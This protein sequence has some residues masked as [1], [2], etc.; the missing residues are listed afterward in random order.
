MSKRLGIFYTTNSS[1]PSISDLQ[2]VQDNSNPNRI[3]VGNPD[4]KPNYVH[5]LRIN[6][7][8]WQAMTGKYIWSGANATL[9]NNAFANST[10]FD[11]FGR[12]T[13]KTENVDGNFFANIFAG[14]GFPILNRKIEFSPNVNAS[15]TKYSNFINSQQ[16]ITKNTALSGGL[17]IEFQLDS[18]EIEIS[19]S[20]SYNNPVSSLSASSNLP[21]SAQNYAIDFKWTLPAHIIVEFDAEYSINSQRANGYNKNLF[22]INAEIKKEFGARQNTILSIQAN[23]ILNQNLTVQR[24]LNG[25]IVTDNFTK[26]ISRYFLMKLTYKFNNNKTKEDDFSGWH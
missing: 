18:L 11:S 19:Q 14:V 3:K 7:N 22:I 24:Q 5:N 4:L 10:N 21:Y 17:S 16:N 23:D 13:S 15:Y 26:I 6:F 20:Y 12:Q 9:T 1:Q 25:N 2:P 8:S